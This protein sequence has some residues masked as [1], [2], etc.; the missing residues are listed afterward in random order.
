MIDEVVT[1]RISSEAF[2]GPDRIEA[3]R[4][5][6][7]RQMMKLEIEPL[8]G[9]PFELDF[10]VQG[11]ADFGFAS[12]WLT[13]TRNTHSADMLEDDD[14]SNRLSGFAA[15]PH[16]RLEMWTTQCIG[17]SEPSGLRVCRDGGSRR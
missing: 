15:G 14:S 11:F 10:L 5:I 9:H 6:Y 1:Q 3:F 4:E 2:S 7:G 13:P 8:P 16:L 17:A 12:G